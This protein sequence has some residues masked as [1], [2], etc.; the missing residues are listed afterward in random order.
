M[1]LGG[2]KFSIFSVKHF[3]KTIAALFSKDPGAAVTSVT[4]WV[5]DGAGIASV[6]AAAG[7]VGELLK[8]ACD[9][10][11]TLL[12]SRALFALCDLEEAHPSECF[13]PLLAAINSLLHLAARGKDD[14]T[15]L[16]AST[17]IA[18]LM[19][20][21]LVHVL[22]DEPEPLLEQGLAGF[23]T[24]FF[25]LTHADDA[26]AVLR[27]LPSALKGLRAL[28]QL[29]AATDAAPP[30]R[31][32]DRAVIDGMAGA[33]RLLL[34]YADEG[35]S[36]AAFYQLLAVRMVKL[37]PR[38]IEKRGL[39]VAG[40]RDS[41]YHNDVYSNL[42]TLVPSFVRPDVALALADVVNNDWPSPLHCNLLMAQLLAEPHAVTK[43]LH[44]A[45]M[46]TAETAPLKSMLEK[47][48]NSTIVQANPS[49]V[50]FNTDFLFS[51][52]VF[53]LGPMHASVAKVIQKWTRGNSTIAAVVQATLQHPWPG[54][55]LPAVTSLAALLASTR[56]QECV[57]ALRLQLTQGS[58]LEHLVDAILAGNDQHVVL[59]SLITVLKH[60]NLWRDAGADAPTGGAKRK[61]PAFANEKRRD[62]TELT[63]ENGAASFHVDIT[64]VTLY[65]KMLQDLL[66]SET[67]TLSSQ[68][69]F[70][71]DALL[72]GLPDG[73][74]PC[75]AFTA[76][77]EFVHAGGTLSPG[78]LE[79][80]SVT[81]PALYAVAHVL[82]MDS[83][84]TWCVARLPP[85][86]DAMRP[87]KLVACW[88]LGRRRPSDGEPLEQACAAAWLRRSAA[89]QTQR[90]ELFEV[91]NK[92][93]DNHGRSAAAML[94]GVLR[95][96]LQQ[97]LP[98]V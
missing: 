54:Y 27:L 23:V 34:K 33:T 14:H 2:T 63:L 78:F 31:T 39:A 47:L 71:L 52:F 13:M 64:A 29:A 45:T 17:L 30:L 86:L 62:T 76:A 96:A 80:K 3:A 74:D 49:A 66:A 91:L 79:E 88:E 51:E 38:T 16:A 7:V 40:I 84:L 46:T 42:V 98:A 22:T 50:L 5:A 9:D 75:D 11:N 95:T 44:H 93:F 8:L 92:V 41:L 67:E 89:A 28:T 72:Q 68:G 48:L 70:P 97:R 1:T 81:L 21:A 32:T 94:V 18:R 25:A 77:M 69:P 55:E 59:A 36:Q 58:H 6:L 10:A 15:K 87:S 26:D 24:A 56:R 60:A 12:R 43:I 57:P 82:Q 19:R 85:K 65:S 4:E 53:G 61:S 83:L 90:E 35:G 20:G 37:L 73:T